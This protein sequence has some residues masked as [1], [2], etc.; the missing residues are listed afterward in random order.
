MP[1]ISR[2]SANF[3]SAGVDH[4]LEVARVGVELDERLQRR[5]V[6]RLNLQRLL[7]HVHRLG[8][9]AE[10]QLDAPQAEEDVDDLVV[11]LGVAVVDQDRLVDAKRIVPVLEPIQQP[12]A[13][14]Q[15]RQVGRIEVV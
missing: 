1:A 9:L 2:E 3:S 5:A 14:D 15:R 11:L 7:E 12:G 10:L 6:A 13:I 4:R 8:A